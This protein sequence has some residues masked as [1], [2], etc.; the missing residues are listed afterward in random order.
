MNLQR[1][2]QLAEKINKLPQEYQ[3]LLTD[4]QTAIP[5]K[6]YDKTEANFHLLNTAKQMEKQVET[7]TSIDEFTA[8]N[9]TKCIE[10]IIE[11]YKK[12]HPLYEK[13]NQVANKIINIC[14]MT[15]VCYSL[16]MIALNAYFTNYLS[17]IWIA[18]ILLIIT[19]IF[20]Y[21]KIPVCRKIRLA[22]IYIYSDLIVYALVTLICMFTSYYFM[23]FL[24]I[25]DICYMF[26]LQKKVVEKAI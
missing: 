24:W 26:Y 20:M 19:F 11:E 22:R 6:E 23:L 12:Q 13:R 1:N 25:Y 4:I 14:L 2:K 3:D 16:F 8:S 5:D 21:I 10:L 7:G 15:L 17:T 9:S 18:V